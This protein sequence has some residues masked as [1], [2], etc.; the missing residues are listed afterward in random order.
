MLNPV[1]WPFVKAL[2]CSAYFVEIGLRTLLFI[3]WLISTNPLVS[4]TVSVTSFA[5]PDSSLSSMLLLQLADSNEGYFFSLHEGMNHVVT[6]RLSR[7]TDSKMMKPTRKFVSLSFIYLCFVQN[8][9]I[10]WTQARQ[11]LGA[12]VLNNYKDQRSLHSWFTKAYLIS[13]SVVAVR[14][15]LLPNINYYVYTRKEEKQVLC[16]RGFAD[17]TRLL[18][19][20]S[21]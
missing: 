1:Q 12:W 8:L 18:S 16:S 5:P 17:T 3:Y 11:F 13:V 15:P 14:L 6:T 2:F 21:D 4:V 7:P 9:S 10:D 19:H 20:A